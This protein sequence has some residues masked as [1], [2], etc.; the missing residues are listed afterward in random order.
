MDGLQKMEVDVCLK[1]SIGE[2]KNNEKVQL[3]VSI[4]S[5]VKTFENIQRDYEGFL[6]RDCDP[7]NTEVSKRVLNKVVTD[8][9]VF[10]NYYARRLQAFRAQ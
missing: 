6:E 3:Q 7:E 9:L 10:F 8:M 5:V 4:R 2:R 1:E